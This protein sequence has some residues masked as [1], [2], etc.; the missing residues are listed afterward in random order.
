[1]SGG[2]FGPGDP[3]ETRHPRS[4]FFRPHSAAPPDPSPGRQGVATAGAR[5]RPGTIAPG[6]GAL[7]EKGS[8][9]PD[10]RLPV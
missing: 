2:F 5:K 8:P 6:W 4:A 1:M 7:L 9:G 3:F 10:T